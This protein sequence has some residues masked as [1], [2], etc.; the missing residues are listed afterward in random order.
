M[1]KR[2]SFNAPFAGLSS[3]IV[4]APASAPAAASRDEKPAG[5]LALEG[6]RRLPEDPRRPFQ[7][8]SDALDAPPGQPSAR[9]ARPRG[10][11][12]FSL[13][14][15]PGDAMEGRASG[16]SDVRMRELRRGDHPPE[17]T[18]DLH[19][20]S[21]EVGRTRLLAFLQRARVA[22]HRCVLIVHGRGRRS[23]PAGPVLRSVAHD[24]LASEGRAGRVLAFTPAPASEG[25]EG[26]TLVLL[27][28]E[29]ATG[30][31]PRR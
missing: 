25:G 21:A 3:R 22:G 2:K 20:C 12:T 27:R 8:L 29:L 13:V 11:E 17:D 4:P 23:G 9:A 15:R 10:R 14:A 5:E 7:V 31:A 19:G 28:R 6:V 24:E 26:A 1:S 30:R 18:L 16:I